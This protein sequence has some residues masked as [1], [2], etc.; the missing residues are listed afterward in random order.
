M[1]KITDDLLLL[2]GGLSFSQRDA[3]G[4]ALRNIFTQTCKDGSFYTLNTKTFLWSKLDQIPDVTPRAYHAAITCQNSSNDSLRV[5][6]NGGVTYQGFE[7]SERLPVNEFVCVNFIGKPP[8]NCYLEK[9]TVPIDI[10]MYISYHSV[11]ISNKCLYILGGYAQEQKEITESPLLHD[12]MKIFNLE[13]KSCISLPVDSS[14]ATCGH[15][16]FELS[17]DCFMFVG[18]INDSLFVYT[19]KLMQPLPSDFKSDCKIGNSPEIPPIAWIQCES[20][21]RRWL[22][23]FCVGLLHKRL[24]RGKYIC[25]KCKEEKPQKKK[26]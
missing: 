9:I 13:N 6:Y 5:I 18:G 24:P 10:P 12:Q 16:C 1:T 2:H 20:S 23:Q 22:H 11:L 8:E 15:S 7:P 17:E 4:A 3:S 19:N 21:C 25:E 14:Y 26:K